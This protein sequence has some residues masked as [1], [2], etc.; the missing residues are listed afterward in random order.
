MWLY[1]VESGAIMR[2]SNTA[3][4]GYSGCL[5][6][7]NDSAYE[8]IPDVGPIPKGLYTIGPFFDDL[9]GKGPLVAHLTPDP[10]NEMY[11]R[12]GFMIHGDNAA[13]NHTAS[14]GCII[15]AHVIRQAIADS[16]DTALEVF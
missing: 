16:G 2:H 7:L 4:Y 14:H 11:G 3:G 6:G 9:G 13:V 5:Q 10:V 12:A 1:E 15:A 8:N